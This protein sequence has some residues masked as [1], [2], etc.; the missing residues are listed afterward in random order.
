MNAI[1][2][3]KTLAKVK[4]LREQKA[5][6]ALQKAR[7]E[8]LEGER[9]VDRLTA[10]LIE[11]ARTLPDRIQALFEEIIGTPVS[12]E[13]IDAVKFRAAQLEADHQKIA[14]RKARAEHTLLSLRER[15]R[16]ALAGYKA[17]QIDREKYDDL[18]RDL[19]AN[20]AALATAAEEVEVEDLFA[21]PRMMNGAK[22]ATR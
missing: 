5:L 7:I 21:R 14:D 4:S 10:Q 20:M 9:K 11:S 6:E 18:I 3:Y 12:L 13:E 22:E 15:T 2:Q 1:V 19:K 16:A 8:E 17:A